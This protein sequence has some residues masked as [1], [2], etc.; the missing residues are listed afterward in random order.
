[1][2]QS[3]FKLK[4]SKQSREFIY[5]SIFNNATMERLEEACTCTPSCVFIGLI[6]YPNRSKKCEKHSGL[7]KSHSAIS[8]GTTR[9]GKQA[10]ALP[11]SQ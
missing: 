11:L 8:Y 3:Y 4:F 5:L 2:V 10:N 6:V 7:R 1:M 9:I